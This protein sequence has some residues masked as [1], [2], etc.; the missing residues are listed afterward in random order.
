[1]VVLQNN[2]KAFQNYNVEDKYEAGIELE[3]W[4]VKSIENHQVDI[5]NSFIKI[6]NNEAFWVNAR[7]PAWKLGEEKSKEEENRERRLL[8]NRNEIKKI[9]QKQERVGYSIVPL[10]IYRAGSNYI[11]L[12]IGIGKG[13]KKFDKRQSLKEKDQKR[14]IDMDRKRYN[15]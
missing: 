15:F 6:R 12:E 2:K 11:K 10:K 7:I 1:M 14:R 8:L 4:E 5:A 3:G 13:K 9:T